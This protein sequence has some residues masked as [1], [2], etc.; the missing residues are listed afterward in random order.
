MAAAC[1]VR[2]DE[3]WRGG[4][5]GLCDTTGQIKIMHDFAQSWGCGVIVPTPGQSLDTKHNDGQAVPPDVW[6]TRYYNFSTWLC[7]CE[8]CRPAG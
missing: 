5:A 7:S 4:W 3:S 2:F 6:W 8:S 1:V